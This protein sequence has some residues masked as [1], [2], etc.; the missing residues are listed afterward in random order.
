MQHLT[1]PEKDVLNVIKMF[2]TPVRTDFIKR[3]LKYPPEMIDSILKKLHE[4]GFVKHNEIENSY[5]QNP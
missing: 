2:R 5:E 4:G 1:H 3:S